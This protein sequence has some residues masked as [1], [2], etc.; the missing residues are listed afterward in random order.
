MYASCCYVPHKTIPR[1]KSKILELSSDLGEADIEYRPQSVR[2]YHR[3]PI[4]I[5][6]LQT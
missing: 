5:K 1:L 6:E 3:Y 2:C 4:T